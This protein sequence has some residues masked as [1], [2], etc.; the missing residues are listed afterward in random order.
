MCYF[1]SLNK[2]VEGLL[3]LGFCLGA[4]FGVLK[5]FSGYWSYFI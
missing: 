2:P 4:Y 5:I 3:F 1:I